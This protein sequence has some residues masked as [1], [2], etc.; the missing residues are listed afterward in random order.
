MTQ[1]TTAD[2]LAYLRGVAEEGRNAPLLGGRFHLWWGAWTAAA[3]LAHGSVIAGIAPLPAQ[4]IWAIWVTYG[5]LGGVVS[6]VLSAGMRGKPGGGAIAN[7]VEARVWPAAMLGLGAFAVGV[8]A[9]IITGNADWVLVDMIVPAAFAAYGV[10]FLMTALFSARGWLKLPAAVC[11]V[12]AVATPMLG[13]TALLYG[14][15]AAVILAVSVPTG[16]ALL[17]HEPGR[18]TG[19]GA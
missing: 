15:A 8:F 17:R 2:D 13:G 19:E 6:G 12:T 5:V 4:W 7:R 10:A 16:L 3:W 1:T 9:A 18:V 11:Y 14:V